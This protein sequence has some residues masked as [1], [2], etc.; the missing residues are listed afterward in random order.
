[1]LAF[2][3]FMGSCRHSAPHITL[4]LREPC[5][6]AAPA[7]WCL[8]SRTAWSP[9][10]WARLALTFSTEPSQLTRALQ[11]V[12]YLRVPQAFLGSLFAVDLKTPRSCRSAL[13]IAVLASSPLSILKAKSSRGLHYHWH[14]ESFCSL[15]PFLLILSQTV[16][17]RMS[18]ESAEPAESQVCLWRAGLN[19]QSWAL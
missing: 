11:C 2:Q 14:P 4:T 5:R 6:L 10:L 7:V 8:P 18:S 9:R 13:W 3:D 19:G 1:M 12:I 15:P 16:R 17:K